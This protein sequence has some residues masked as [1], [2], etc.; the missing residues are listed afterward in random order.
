VFANLINVL[1]KANYWWL[2][3]SL[4]FGFLAYL[5]RARRW[6][7]LI[8]AL[9]YKPAFFSTFNALMTG[10]LANLALPRVGEIT[11]CVALGLKEKIPVDQLIGTVVMERTIDFVSLLLITIIMMLTS[12]KR[13]LQFINES[14]I[15]PVKNQVFSFFALSWIFWVIFMTIFIAALFLMIKHR[16]HL[17]RI[18]LFAKLFSITRGI[19]NGLRTI[20]KIKR[21][22]EFILQ[23]VFIWVC[24]TLMTW[25]VVFSIPGTSHLTFRDG[26]FLLVIGGIG[27]LAPV[28][29]GIGAFHY[30]V[31][32]GLAFVQGVSLEDGAAYALL[33]HESQLIF[34]AIVGTICFFSIFRKEKK[35]VLINPLNPEIEETPPTAHP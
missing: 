13:I 3:L 33:T 21:K 5:M 30:I 2:V 4:F 24:Y 31:S 7:L 25:V 8:N 11:R 17:L 29:G 18:R 16:R 14:I 15:D 10:Y 28:P 23:T 32:R 19:I 9:G 26:I 20:T 27:M 34:V 22:W 35:S 1:K 6:V 12:R